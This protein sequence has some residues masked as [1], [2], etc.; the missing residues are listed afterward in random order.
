MRRGG[1]QALHSSWMSSR[2]STQSDRNTWAAEHD[3]WSAPQH[4]GQARESS[5]IDRHRENVWNRDSWQCSQSE[6]NWNRDG[7]WQ[8]SG[9]SELDCSEAGRDSGSNRPAA[10]ASDGVLAPDEVLRGLSAGGVRDIYSALFGDW[11]AWSHDPWL[12]TDGYH[13]NMRGQDELRRRFQSWLQE[14]VWIG[15]QF[16]A[17]VSDS[18]FFTHD[19]QWPDGRDEEDKEEIRSLGFASAYMRCG[20]GFFRSG[21]YAKM[22]EEAIE[23]G[24]LRIARGSRVLIVTCGNDLW[25]N[26]ETEPLTTEACLTSHIHWVRQV[27]EPYTTRVEM[28]SVVDSHR[29]WMVW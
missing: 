13:F 4:S 28:V 11:S 23:S 9:S 8:A 16:D 18:L 27:L 3:A 15:G 19:D 26:A 2:Y 22:I 12:Y 20:V 29:D 6:Q 25:C 17:I 7:W 14:E 5:Q 24:E 21:G 10:S 1:E